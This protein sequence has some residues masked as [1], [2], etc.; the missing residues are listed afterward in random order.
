MAVESNGLHILRENN[1][2][3]GVCEE[4]PCS[5]KQPINVIQYSSLNIIM[6]GKF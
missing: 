2:E 4:G 1:E 6:V 5:S 3:I